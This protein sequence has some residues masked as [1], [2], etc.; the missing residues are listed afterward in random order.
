MTKLTNETFQQKSEALWGIGV[1][2]YTSVV[3]L[4]YGINVILICAKHSY[5]FEQTPHQ[6]LRTNVK[7]KNTKINGCIKCETEFKKNLHNEK[8]IKFVEKFKEITNREILNN[9]FICIINILLGEKLQR[10][11]N[12]FWDNKE[13]IDCY[14]N[15]FRHK[16]NITTDEDWYNI[17]SDDVGKNDG[18]ALMRRHNDSLINFLKWYHPERE[19][20]QW[21]FRQVQ[22]HYWDDKDNRKKCFEWLVKKLNYNTYEEYYNLQQQIFID[23]GVGR[24]VGYYQDSTLNLLKDLFSENLWLPWKFGQV[25]KSF[26]WRNKDNSKL[27]LEWFAKEHNYKTIEDWYKITQNEIKKYNGAGLLWHYNGSHLSMLSDNYPE[28]NWLPWLF[29]GASPNNYWNEPVNVKQYLEWLSNKIDCKSES[30]WYSKSWQDIYDNN[31]ASLRSKYNSF[32][33]LLSILYPSYIFDTSKFK[34]AGYSKGSCKF[35][36]ML[37]ESIKTPIRHK[38]N[39]GEYK[40]PET[41][42]RHADGFISEYKEYKKIVIEYHGCVFHGCPLCYEDLSGTNY[43]GQ[44]YC[45]LLSNTLTRSKE[46]KAY[47][48]IVIEIWGCEYATLK[49]QN[50]DWKKWFEDKLSEQII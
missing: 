9:K 20:L 10:V 43:H 40:I 35:L 44:K 3:Y 7:G 12:G 22:K 49:R 13:A 19:F 39:G 38:L 23:N 6:H 24:L 36:D 26:D 42:N 48:Y 16:Y 29:E 31:G 37:S 50:T 14:I 4:G 30:D 45:D 8:T 21:K 47:G 28:Y 25:S 1:W 32:E 15:W 33:D 11:P 34:V 2:I 41:K 5:A 17:K 46:L 18:Y 27:W